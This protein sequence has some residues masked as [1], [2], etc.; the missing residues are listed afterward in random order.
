MDLVLA[1]YPDA[2]EVPSYFVRQAAYGGNPVTQRSLDNVPAIWSTANNPR[3]AEFVAQGVPAPFL[4]GKE[5]IHSIGH[6]Q[7]G[8][9]GF[10]G[11][12]EWLFLGDLCSHGVLAYP[13]PEELGPII[14]RI[15]A[16]A[17][18]GLLLTGFIHQA[19]P[20]G[21][22]TKEETSEGFV[23]FYHAV[24]TAFQTLPFTD[25]LASWNTVVAEHVLCKVSRLR[26]FL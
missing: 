14:H 19:D 6:G 18:G 25:P 2:E 24:E 12:T 3:W 13:T 11:L 5:L 17:K 1:E 7:G 15:N 8:I 20:V 21:R 16:G 22:P 9:P 4:A 26:K 10:G 23:R